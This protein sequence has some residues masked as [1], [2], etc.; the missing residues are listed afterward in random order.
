LKATV[1]RSATLFGYLETAREVGIDGE[2]LMAKLGLRNDFAENPDVLLPMDTVVTLFNLS[3]IESGRSDFGARAAIARGVPDYGP[4]SLLLR[5]EETLGDALRTL[6]A[7]LPYHSD[8]VHLELD[9]RFG[10]PF[11]A[12]RI[13]SNVPSIQVAEYCA[14]GLVQS[15]RWLIGSD[16]HPDAVCQEHARPLHTSVQHNFL[17]CDLRYNQVM[18]G[19]LLAHDALDLKVVTSTAVLRRHAKSAVEHTLAGSPDHFEAQVARIM[20]QRMRE[21]SCDADSV[22]SSLGMNRR[23]LHRRLAS[24]GL[25]YSTLLQQVRRET[26]IRLIELGTVPLTEVAEALGFGSQSSFSR[27]FQ[28]TFGYSA[29][30]WKRHG[31]ASR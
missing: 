7:R 29:S 16:W 8:G 10:K 26:S 21:S 15:I 1:V 30:N 22:A 18:G 27:W 20:S 25:S 9:T 2:A 14:C 4:V 31:G 3:A 12:F 11:L 17:R 6:V 13:V 19:I 28:T 24:K 5:E 23:T